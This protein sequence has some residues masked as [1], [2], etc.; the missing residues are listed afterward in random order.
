M[1]I[2]LENSR[3][4]YLRQKARPSQ[5]ASPKITVSELPPSNSISSPTYMYRQTFILNLSKKSQW[6]LYQNITRLK[7]I[8]AKSHSF[9]W[10]LH[11]KSL[12]SMAPPPKNACFYS[13]SA[14]KRFCRRHLHQKSLPLKPP[15]S[16]KNIKNPVH[17]IFMLCNVNQTKV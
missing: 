1:R 13:A 10:R 15:P 3:V 8:S 5:V 2:V 9:L 12:I 7:S 11:Q 17:I 16:R 6:R 14:K 4:K